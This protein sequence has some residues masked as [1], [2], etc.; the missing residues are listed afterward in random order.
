MVNNQVMI[1]LF[2]KGDSISLD[3]TQWL[4]ILVIILVSIRSTLTVLFLIFP[5]LNR[6][7]SESFSPFTFE[8]T[9]LYLLP[10]RLEDLGYI[11]VLFGTG[12]DIFYSVFLSKSFS[13]TLAHLSLALLAVDFIRYHYFTDVFRLRL[14]DLPNPVLQALESFLIC[15]R[16]Y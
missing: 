14:L 3:E 15:D 5:W 1:M 12:L 9:I 11:M 6:H 16:I 10:N 8:Q 2:G 4:Y 13:L 7:L